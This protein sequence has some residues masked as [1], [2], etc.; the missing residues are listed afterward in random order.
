MKKLNVK[1][2]KGGKEYRAAIAVCP[3]TPSEEFLCLLRASL[4]IP[5]AVVIGFKDSQGVLLIPSLICSDPGLLLPD[6]YEL[7]L[8]EKPTLSRPDDQFSHIISEIRVNNHLNDEEYFALRSWMREN[9]QM[10]AQVYQAYLVKHDLEGFMEWL[11]KSS[12]TRSM[13]SSRLLE[14]PQILEVPRSNEERPATSRVGDRPRT[15]NQDRRSYQNYMQIMGEMEA[16][17]LLE[18]IDVRII[19]ALILRE[20]FGVMRE[21][22][23]YFLHSISLRE[24]GSRLQKLADKLSLYMERPSSPMQKN[25]QLEFLV[26]SFARDSLIALEDIEVLKKLIADKNE[27]VLSAFDVFESD[28]DQAELVDSLMRAIKK[29]TRPAADSI[30]SSSFY[31]NPPPVE[32]APTFINQEVI[33]K[34]MSD[35]D[36]SKNWSDEVNGT[37]KALVD[38]G[39]SAVCSAFENYLMHQEQEYLETHLYAICNSYFHFLLCTSFGI[40]KVKEIKRAMREEESPI[41][42]VIQKFGCE[43]E[44]SQMVERLAEILQVQLSEHGNVWEEVIKILEDFDYSDYNELEQL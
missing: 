38:S 26:D 43:G 19:K 1:L 21:F 11:L 30:R 6:D 42:A 2:T 35:L 29:H 3:G 9:N 28:R 17:G 12:I 18:Q 40:E 4:P 13:S 32:V 36:L 27:F 14:K 8:R 15:S 37:L 7:I 5:D 31:P 41:R 16:Q 10:T 44:C 22:D 23:Y 24:L 39:S 33:M 20:N 34:I 25:N